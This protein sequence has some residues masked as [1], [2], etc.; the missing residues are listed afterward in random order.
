MDEATRYET[1]DLPFYRAEVA[2]V[3]PPKVL[4]AH[5][6][7]WSAAGWRETPWD[8]GKPGAR[9]MV[10]DEEYPVE[11]LLADGQ[12]C[13]PDREYHAVCFGNPTPAVEWSRDTAYVADASRRHGT[14]W[15]LVI[16]GPDLE[17]SRERYV[18]ALD[19]GGFYGFKV[20][21]NWYGDN[22]GDRRVEDMVGPVERALANER[23]LVVLLHVPRRDRLADPEVQRG[24]QWLAAECPDASIVLAHCGRCYLPAEMKAA[25]GAIRNLS[26]VS[27]D[28]SM[29]MDPVVLQIALNE[30][31]PRRLLFGTDFPP[32]RMRGRRVRVMDHW[33]DVVAPGYPHSAFRVPGDDIHATFMAWEIVVAIRWAADLCGVAPSDV[34]RIFWDNGMSLLSR[35]AHRSAG[36]YGTT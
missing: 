26:N 8:T 28:T 17:V 27:M 19:R 29:V 18:Q 25:I 9:Y 31:G 7:L 36:R 4:D 5:A 24:V 16:A 35:V 6:H 10:T 21:L 12:R 15:P 20:F 13:F 23:R 34:H 14:L 2:P 11:T 30:I 1:R 22:Y 32:A 3:L 33:V